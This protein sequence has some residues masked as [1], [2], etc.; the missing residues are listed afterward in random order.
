VL[1]GGLALDAPGYYL[2]PTVVELD[3]PSGP[4]ASDEVFAPVAALIRADS[5]DR[6]IQI[7]NE[8]RYGLVAAVFTSDLGRALRLSR[9]LEAGMIRVNAPTSGVDFN[10]PFGG[11]K[12]SSYG[13]REQGQAARAF[14]TESRTVLIVP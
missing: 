2:A 7:A 14:Y 11:S 9:A 1:T 3:G 13:P 8:V 12:E 6:A 10:A 4:L 5:E